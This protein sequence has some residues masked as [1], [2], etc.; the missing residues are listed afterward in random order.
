MTSAARRRLRR[1]VKPPWLGPLRS[2]HPL[3]EL[4]G[5]DRGTPV[6][7]F[8]IERFLARH[9]GDIRGRVLEVGDAR[10]ATEFGEQ[11]S[12]VDVLDIRASNAAA[13]IVAD[14]STAD[15]IAPESYD[16]FVL[17]QTLQYIAD[18]DAALR[19]ARRILRPRGVLLATVP[20]LAPLDGRHLDRDTW[21]FT[22]R[23][24]EVLLS[25]TWPDDE[26][27]VTAHGNVLAATAF[28]YGIAQEELS[29]EELVAEDVRFPVTISIRAVRHA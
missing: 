25:R 9:R 22:A 17:T 13:T 10:Y 18:V 26:V 24:C 1:L 27:S 8:Y 12:A 2:V 16:C 14:L 11:V 19:Q 20:G 6:D 4:W 29:P 15:E 23:A 21:R 7:R 28:L 3:S 5:I